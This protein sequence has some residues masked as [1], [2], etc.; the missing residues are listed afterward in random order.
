MKAVG[1]ISDAESRVLAVLWRE[2]RST[3]ERVIAALAQ[4]NWE[5]STIKTLLARLVRKR[6]VRA[7][8]VGR[9]YLYSAVLT[10]EQWITTESE[11]M[12]GRLFGGR[13]APLVQHFSE[14]RRLS[15]V[16]IAE[17]KRLIGELDD[18]E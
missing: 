5:V 4:E 10:R 17:L 15:K 18:G 7:K 11:G 6:A 9:R 8:K 13:V 12:L 1:S 3:S 2:G 14:H 16:D